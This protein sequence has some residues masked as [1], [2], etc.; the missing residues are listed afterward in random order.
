MT[1]RY[2][3]HLAV[4]FCYISASY[5]TRARLD[6][7]PSLFLGENMTRRNWPDYAVPPN[8]VKMVLFGI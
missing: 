6:S 5:Q 2:G 1:Y 4:S 3:K 7:S 8:C